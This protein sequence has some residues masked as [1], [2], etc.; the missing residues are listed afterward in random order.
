MTTI[1]VPTDFSKTAHNA[2]AYAFEM[3]RRTGAQISLL[4]VIYPNQGVENNVYEAFWIDT[5]VEERVR[6][7]RKLAQKFQRNP[8][9]ENVQVETEAAIG[10]PVSEI[11]RQAKKIKADLIV[12]GT[13]GAT[14]LRGVFLGS[15]AGGVL[16]KTAAPVLTVPPKAS[17][18]EGG[19]VVYA[20]DFRLKAAPSALEVLKNYLIVHRGHLK[21]LHVMDKPGEPDK[22]LEASF[23]QKIAGIPHDFHY[24][25]D[26]NIQQAVNNF[27]EAVDA[28]GL[29]A[30]AH[31]H[32]LLHKLFF[33]SVTRQ[34]AHQVN[35]PVLAL[36]D[37]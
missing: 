3:A 26:R 13:T 25:H 23:S 24:L 1:L 15:I 2:L 11:S 8:A 20:T 18:K 28:V 16:S 22:K 34:L 21:V 35:V 10:F 17:F 29:V 36:H 27:L 5:Y 12:M 14:G 33:E 9:F 37:A 31:E 32:S 30:V 19:S 7:L 4:H 6:A